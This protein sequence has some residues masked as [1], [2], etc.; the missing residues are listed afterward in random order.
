[1]LPRCR[2]WH[3]ETDWTEQFIHTHTEAY[4]LKTSSL[5]QLAKIN[6]GMW[7]V[8]MAISRFGNPT[9]FQKESTPLTLPFFL[10]QFRYPATPWSMLHNKFSLPFRPPFSY[11]FLTVSVRKETLLTSWK[12]IEYSKITTTSLERF[13]L[14][15]QNMA[16]T[17]VTNFLSPKSDIPRAEGFQS[18]PFGFYWL[19]IIYICFICFS[20]DVQGRHW[21]TKQTA[22]QLAF[23]PSFRY[24]EIAKAE[25]IN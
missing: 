19:D 1:M 9:L 18:H 25:T 14:N 23:A 2:K 5:I 17:N 7:T 3:Q 12:K 21:K 6:W 11:K 8:E 22:S 15:G 24:L 20:S 4:P 13:H 10:A 16:C